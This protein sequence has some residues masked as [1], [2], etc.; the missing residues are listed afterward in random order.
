MQEQCEIAYSKMKVEIENLYTRALSGINSEPFIKTL[1]K[2]WKVFYS[3]LI[4]R[5]KVLFIGINP[6]NGEEG[7]YDCEHSDK[8]ELEY[9]H[10][11][12]T[13][14]EESIKAFKMAERFEAL[15]H[16]TKTNYYYLATKKAKDIFEI[17]DFLGRAS[18]N[19]LGEM[20]L[21]NARKWT[22][23]MI[24]IMEPQLIICEGSDA[25]KNVTD[26]FQ[27]GIKMK[28]DVEHIYIDEIQAN[29]IGYKRISYS[30]IKDKEMLAE[31]LSILIRK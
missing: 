12:Y 2:G 1:F 17:T 30:R 5:P 8:G 24:E 27:E 11:D 22:K 28:D 20:I 7:V 23:Q 25:Y 26:L 31:K 9:L 21:V 14:A 15:Y 18:Q 19:D 29:I 3:P 4:F 10:Y 6:G 16:S 13:L